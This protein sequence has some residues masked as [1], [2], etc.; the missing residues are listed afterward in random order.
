[1][2]ILIDGGSTYNFIQPRIVQQVKLLVTSS[3][4]FQVMVGNGDKLDYLGSAK[5]M[6]IQIHGHLFYMDYYIILIQ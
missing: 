6:P 2:Q 5:S 3:N 4:L 1:M